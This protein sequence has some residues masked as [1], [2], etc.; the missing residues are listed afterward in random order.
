MCQIQ[1]KIESFKEI[2]LQSY[3]KDFTFIVN[4]KEF[5]TSKIESDLLSSK[6]SKIHLNDPT[7]DNIIINTQAQGDFSQFLRLS[8]FSTN[9]IPENE[10]DFI[11]E[12]ID[13]LGSEHITSLTC[14][15]KLTVDNIFQIMKK[16]QKRSRFDQKSHSEIIEF[17]SSHF[18][19]L[20]SS[21]KEEF[22]DFDVNSL[23]EII[24]NDHL[25]LNSEDQLLEF[26]NELYKLDT[27]YSILYDEILFEN[28]SSKTI[29][30][31]IQIFDTEKMSQM[32]WIHL[33]DRLKIEIQVAQRVSQL[34][35]Y[36]KK[37][38][39]SIPFTGKEFEGIISHIQ[40]LNQN[41]D[42]CIDVT[43]SSIYC[44]DEEFNPRK[45]ILFD[46]T[47]KSFGSLN[48]KGSWI[49]IDFKEYKVSPSHY[50]I[51]SSHAFCNLP[52]S[53]VIEGSNDCDQW[54]VLDEEINNSSIKQNNVVHTFEMNK[55]SSKAFRYIRM[56]NTGP[57]WGGSN[58]LFI[59]A[60]EFY[61]KLI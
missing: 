24:S 17:I 38:S 8:N 52:K 16:H 5:Y 18:G 54:E 53:W 39:F 1:L 4:G 15:Q 6:I 41:C 34:S 48:Q 40:K 33:C 51:R 25:R 57:D 29:Q 31:F 14:D 2:P 43:S 56:K 35:R 12:L 36:D 3:N 44:D 26:V 50:T 46:E 11:N 47:K 28:V 30:E 19:Q 37:E 22:Y 10:L 21:K 32:T 55:P 20:I 60:I 61:G 9:S 13:I 42:N 49:C 58:Y 45:A 59:N 27:K 23:F 7:F